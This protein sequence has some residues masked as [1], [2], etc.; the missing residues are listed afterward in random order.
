[1][2]KQLLTR[3]IPVLSAW[4]HT[5]RNAHSVIEPVGIPD[6]LGDG[7]IEFLSL[8]DVG[9]FELLVPGKR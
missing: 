1:M 4:F 5:E 8:L 3:L 6:L 9:L 2:P 7:N